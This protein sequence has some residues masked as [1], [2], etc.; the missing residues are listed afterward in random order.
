[1]ELV[2]AVPPLSAPGAQPA[3]LFANWAAFKL[4]FERRIF[5]EGTQRLFRRAFYERTQRAGES[6]QE[7]TSALN[8]V[9]ERAFG[10]Q[11]A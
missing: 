9:A 7:F 1:M 3:P 4:A 11:A 5:P 8:T 2:N 6:I 10:P